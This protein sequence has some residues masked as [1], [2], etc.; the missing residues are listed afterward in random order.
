MQG[1]ARWLLV[2]VAAPAFAAAPPPVTLTPA[3][4]AAIGIT[5]ASLAADSRT[6]AAARFGVASVLDTTPF[7]QLVDD[8]A[9]ADAMAAASTADAARQAALFKG[10]QDVSARAVEAARAQALA[11]AAHARTAASRFAV[12]WSP[13]LANPSPALVAGL[14]SGNIRLLRIEALSDRSQLRPGQ[15]LQMTRARSTAP[16]TATVIGAASGVSAI[17]SG[18]AWLAQARG[19]GLHSGEPLDII[20]PVPAAQSGVL[21]PASAVIIAGGQSWL[22]RALGDGRFQRVALPAGSSAA[23][24]GFHTAG[25]AAGTRVVTRGAATLLSIEAGSGEH[26]E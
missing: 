9:A 6:T 22:F 18:P 3:K 4:A 10:H 25:L 21:V 14:R 12:E 23:P 26:D 13:A 5:T 19:V 16:L 8:R 2:L 1:F 7:L 20:A 15:R 24:G 17:S 11:D